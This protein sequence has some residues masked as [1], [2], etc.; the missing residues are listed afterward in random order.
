MAGQVAVTDIEAAM[1]RRIAMTRNVVLIH[2]FAR[3]FLESQSMFEAASQTAKAASPLVVPGQEKA[4][5]EQQQVSQFASVMEQQAKGA[6]HNMM[7][8]FRELAGVAS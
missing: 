3:E 2:R 4:P 6:Y 5:S 8:A 1:L 7:M